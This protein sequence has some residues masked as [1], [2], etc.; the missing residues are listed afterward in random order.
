MNA[1]VDVQVFA[2]QVAILHRLS[3]LSLVTTAI[4]TPLVVM[5]L[6]GAVPLPAV[7]AWAAAMSGVTLA[8]YV[9]VRRY[10]AAVAEQRVQP[11]RFMR[12]F[13]VGAVAAGLTWGVAAILFLPTADIGAR[14]ALL[15]L[16]AVVPA[17]SI[18]SL[19]SHRLAF[20][21]FV[22][23][24]LAS[25]ALALVYIGD[26][27]HLALAIA[28]VVYAAVLW[29]M[30]QRAH[31]STVEALTQRFDKEA[32]LDQ[33]TAASEAAERARAAAEEA[34][35]AKSMFLATMSHEIR[36][37]MN[38]VLG[39]TELLQRTELTDRQRH[40]ADT[41]QR[42]A[43]D[44][45][46]IINDILDFSKVEAGRLELE[47]VPVD[48]RQ[49]ATDV[50]GLFSDSAARKGIALRSEVA[51]TLAPALGTDPTRLRQVL[52]NLL[53]NAVKF[54]THGEV[55]LR[56]DVDDGAG[57]V[58]GT[59]ALTI[60]VSDTGIGIEP[61]AQA[62]LFRAFSQ[63]DGSTT[64]QYGGTGLGLAIARELVSLMGG[65]IGVQ[66]TP[67]T[68]STF[69][70]RLRLPRLDDVQ[71]SSAPPATAP[72]V[73]VQPAS[74]DAAPQA[75]PAEPSGS[76][77]PLLDTAAQSA[78]PE[79]TGAQAAVALPGTP[80]CRVLLA[81]DN[82]VNRLVA[83]EM[84]QVLGC[85]VT[86]AEHGADALARCQ[87]ATFDLVFMDCQMPTMDGL[88]AARRI[89]EAERV[90]AQPTRTPIVALTANALQSDRDECIGAG[91]DDHLPK[92]FSM[93]E[94]DA[95]VERW[96]GTRWHRRPTAAGKA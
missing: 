73:S 6:Y 2:E 54:T 65:E 93:A 89:R 66:S 80:R 94:L 57:D 63:A 82:P 43:T 22:V 96:T 52:V 34:N 16:M 95:T 86:T 74:Q 4:A 70:V 55:C 69:L 11:R 78:A 27:I 50:L 58:P 67:G 91:M 14:F 64:R 39:M 77:S 7:L 8:R 61:D 15:T 56:I 36:T 17:L 68:G 35:R 29:V 5:L 13:S 47:T 75:P 59:Q 41:V 92:P 46:A 88:E 85:D 71:P 37:P 72:P 84:L 26:R 45:L 81:E 42:S 40:F 49:L 76:A 32:L 3:P 31:A 20:T 21:L 87:A 28:T 9:L 90:R 48:V 12:E 24:M 30:G 18:P 62:R 10:R 33:L 60:S 83:S 51:P 53:G 44:L 23:P 19:G 25:M 79:E 1:Q 38:G